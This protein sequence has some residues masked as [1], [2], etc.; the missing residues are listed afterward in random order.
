MFII[1]FEVHA[2]RY[3]K[4]T[5]QRFGKRLLSKVGHKKI[6]KKLDQN[7]M[8]C[9]KKGKGVCC[10]NLEGAYCSVLV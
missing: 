7:K 5:T 6:H 10:I 9:I 4:E 8:T 3:K 1:F 2:E